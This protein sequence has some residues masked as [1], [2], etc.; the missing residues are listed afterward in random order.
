MI[1]EAEHYIRLINPPDTYTLGDLVHFEAKMFEYEETVYT[2]D[3]ETVT[4]KKW[5]TITLRGNAHLW[6]I[7]DSC[8]DINVNFGHHGTGGALIQHYEAA[9]DHSTLKGI[10]AVDKLAP[11]DYE[12]LRSDNLK[13]YYSEVFTL[14]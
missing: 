12:M 14:G 3:G 5:T 13:W 9:D 8:H 11:V 7:E 1:P 2:L 4:N 6:L 10:L